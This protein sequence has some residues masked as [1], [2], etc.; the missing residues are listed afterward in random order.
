MEKAICV[1]S[2]P[3]P[4]PLGFSGDACGKEPAHNVGQKDVGLILVQEDALKEGMA[5]HS[6]ILSWW[7][8]WTKETWRATVQSYR[9]LNVT[10]VT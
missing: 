2:G 8:P 1:L 7:T 5:F 9:E 3:L 6:S 10:E 4:S